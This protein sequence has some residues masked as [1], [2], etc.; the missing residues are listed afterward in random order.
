MRK[1]NEEYITHPVAVAEI[2]LDLNV[3]YVT[4]CAALLHETINHGATTFTELEETFGKEIANIV[5]I[6]SKIN[7]LKLNDDRESSSIYLRK[8]VVGLSE[9]VRV[10]FIKLADRLHNMRTIWA[11][12]PNEQK[13]KANECF[14][15]YCSSSWYS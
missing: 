6:V 4:I 12:S 14:N 8:I 10:L 2:L 15:S 5:N 9:D 3:D 7:K 11:L 1:T 13:Q